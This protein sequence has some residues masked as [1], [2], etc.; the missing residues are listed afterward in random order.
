MTK[1]KPWKL[2]IYWHGGWRTILESEYRKP[3][4]EYAETCPENLQLRI[5][6]SKE[7]KEHGRRR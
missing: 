3:L 2:Q 5:I 7:D 4:V 6:D 1:D